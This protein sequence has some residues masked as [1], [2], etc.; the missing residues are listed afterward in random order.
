MQTERTAVT[1]NEHITAAH[2]TRAAIVSGEG[3]LDFIPQ[4]PPVVV[5]DEFYGV[6]GDCSFTGYTVPTEGVFCR[7]GVLDE[8]AL[9]ENMAQ[10]AALRVGWLCAAEKKPVPLG[11]IGAVAKCN[12][13]RKVRAGERL[14]TT[15]RVVAEVGGVTLAE[16]RITCGGEEVCSATLKIFLRP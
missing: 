7:D 8:C 10:S 15:V 14:E 3:I 2:G 1:H 11:V 9:I 13:I 6:E 16:A 5:V 4:R 12:I